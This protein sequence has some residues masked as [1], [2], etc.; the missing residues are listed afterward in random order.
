MLNIQYR[1]ILILALS[2]VVDVWKIELKKSFSD[3]VIKYYIEIVIRSVLID[4]SFIFNSSVHHLKNYLTNLNNLNSNTIKIIILSSYS[5]W[6]RRIIDFFVESKSRKNKKKKTISELKVNE[7]NDSKEEKQKLFENILKFLRF[8]IIDFFNRVVLNETHKIKSI[9]IK[10][11]QIIALFE[12]F[13]FIFLTATSMINRS[14]DF[15]EILSMLWNDSWNLNSD[16][17]LN[18]YAVEISETIDVESKKFL[19]FFN[20]T[21]FRRWTNFENDLQMNA[22]TASMMISFILRLLQFRRIM[23]DQMNVL[24]KIVRIEADISSYRI[25]TIELQM[26]FFQTKKYNK[27]HRILSKQLKENVDAKTNEKFINMISHR[28]LCHVILNIALYSIIRNDKKYIHKKINRIHLNDDY[29]AFF[30]HF[31][32]RIDDHFFSYRN[33]I[34]MILYINNI[35]SKF[36]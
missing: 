18:M 24:K 1:S 19:Y 2:F 23:I 32:T 3:L 14:I 20:S 27:I 7:N 29:E 25:T 35:F 9:R 26:S 11:A 33:R 36:Q 8:K 13:H 10:I 22:Q 21:W 15:D 5:I 31:N 30:Y 28:K 4:R 12:A 16:L 17:K 34:I 6:K